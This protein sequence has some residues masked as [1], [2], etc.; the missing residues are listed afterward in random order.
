MSIGLH[1]LLGV[2]VVT[3]PAV[4]PA[5]GISGWGSEEGGGAGV[6]VEIVSNVS[7]IPLPAPM[8]VNEDAA[9]NESAGFYE[10]EPL[11]PPEESTPLDPSAEPVP[12][13]A[14]PVPETIAREEAPPPP[15]TPPPPPAAPERAAAPDN[16]VPFGQGGRPAISYGQFARGDGTGAI[17]VGEGAFGERYGR[18]VESITRRISEN[19]LQSLISADVRAAPRIYVSFDILRDGSIVNERIEESS[20]IPS[21]DRSAM[22]AIFASNPL[23]P[24]PSDFRGRSV[25]VRFWFEYN[26]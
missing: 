1:V 18:Y 25:S 12:V 21:L 23:A 16:A 13:E 4:F 22:R 3:L 2:T 17:G 24:L 7:G 9:A 11:V 6:R 19:W 14:E 15:P 26:R 5:Y 20:G 10:S 8:V